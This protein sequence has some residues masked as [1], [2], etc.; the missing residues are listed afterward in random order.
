MKDEPTMKTIKIDG[1]ALK[2]DA[3]HTLFCECSDCDC[4]EGTRLT[5]PAGV[6]CIGDGA[7]GL[8][9]RLTDVIIPDGVTGIRDMAFNRCERLE[10]VMIPEDVTTIGAWVFQFCD[11]LASVTIPASVTRIGPWAFAE[12]KALTKVTFAEGSN[13]ASED[14]WEHAFDDGL[15]EAYL[16]ASPHAGVYTREPG[17]TVWKK[18]ARHSAV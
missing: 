6:T 5:I 18:G 9:D 8:C 10:S 14:F 13:I 7:F 2:I 15:K 1:C 4:G 3:Q 16:A 17:G 12:C 11:R